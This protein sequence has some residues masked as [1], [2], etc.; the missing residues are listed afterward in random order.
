MNDQIFYKS[1]GED[2]GVIVYECDTTYDIME[3]PQYGGMERLAESHNKEK[4]TKEQIIQMA[5]D[6]SDTWT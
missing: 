2:S 3:I 6:L 5:I 1:L 4:Y